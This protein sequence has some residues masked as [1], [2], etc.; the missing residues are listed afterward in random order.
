[1]H[2]TKCA[3]NHT[4]IMKSSNGALTFHRDMFVEVPIM[5]D[6]IVIQNRRQQL[7]DQ[8]QIWLYCKHYDY[9]YQVGD[10]IMVKVYDP[11]KI[12][13]KIYWP[14]PIIELGT[15]MVV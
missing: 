1:M 6:L 2:T 15:N 4:C 5:V 3:L 13:G 14:Y 11:T 8:N 12:E 9:H 10:R 7:I